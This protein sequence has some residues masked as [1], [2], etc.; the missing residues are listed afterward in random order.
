MNTDGWDTWSCYVLK[1]LERLDERLERGHDDIT[2]TRERLAV[3]SA[4]V[5]ALAVKVERLCA[6]VNA[7][8]VQTRENKDVIIALRIKAGIWGAVGASI[9][10][11][12]LLLW[13]LLTK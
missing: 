8:A 6:L 1:E 3:S 2:E 13:Q 12:A 4:T 11:A 9:P 7:T 5:T 10:T